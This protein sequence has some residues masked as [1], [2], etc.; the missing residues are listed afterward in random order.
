[1]KAANAHIKQRA[2]SRSTEFDTPAR[3]HVVRMATALN[4]SLAKNRLQA[5]QLSDLQRIVSTRKQRQSGKHM[6]LRGETI[7]TTP[8]MLQRLEVAK[9]DTKPRKARKAELM[10]PSTPPST[11]IDPALTFDFP[12]FNSDRD[13]QDGIVVALRR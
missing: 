2:H 4:R 6:I 12:D 13:I 7:L 5:T 11:N 8:E 10:H 9:A 3:K 1:M